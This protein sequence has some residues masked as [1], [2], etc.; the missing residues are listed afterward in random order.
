M[1]NKDKENNHVSPFVVDLSNAGMKDLAL[2]GGKNAS[3]GELIGALSPKGINVAGGF[4]VTSNAYWE[5][6]YSNKFKEPLQK[7]FDRL[8]R[9]NFSN[10]TAVSKSAKELILSGELP[11]NTKEDVI[12]AYH[13]IEKQYGE[14]TDVA[15]GSSATSEDYPVPV[16][17]VCMNHNINN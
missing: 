12:N 14:F 13:A 2:L 4:A 1:I 16:L 5:F 7:I 6:I 8:D 11:D 17:R 3:L 9:K 10:I 15:V